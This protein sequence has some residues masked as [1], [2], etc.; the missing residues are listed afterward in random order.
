MRE[1]WP[2]RFESYFEPP[3]PRAMYLSNA[4]GA[5]DDRRADRRGTRE[6]ADARD[7]QRRR[8]LT[9]AAS[10]EEALVLLSS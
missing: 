10:A 3:T 5:D 9:V 4:L 6:A 2:L 7:A 1:Q 8:F